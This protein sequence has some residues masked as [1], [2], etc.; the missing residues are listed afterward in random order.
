MGA[1]RALSRKDVLQMIFQE[2]L[3]FG[4]HGAEPSQGTQGVQVFL[5]YKQR[6]RQAA[7]TDIFFL[8]F[9]LLPFWGLFAVPSLRIC[10]HSALSVF[11]YLHR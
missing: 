8:F 9:L 3:F 4:M 7:P 10:E 2:F 6:N 1:Q 11:S 5:D